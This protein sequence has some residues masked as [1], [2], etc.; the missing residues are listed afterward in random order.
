VVTLVQGK[1]IATTQGIAAL[2]AAPWMRFV[3]TERRCKIAE[4]YRPANPCP[5]HVDHIRS[6]K[7]LSLCRPGRSCPRARRFRCSYPQ[8]PDSNYCLEVLLLCT[9]CYKTFVAS[10]W[11]RT[12]DLLK[13][14]SC[15][16]VS[17]GW[18]EITGRKNEFGS[19]GVSASSMVQWDTSLTTCCTLCVSDAYQMFANIEDALQLLDCQQCHT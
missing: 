3:L 15:L 4:I 1:E 11:I 13:H 6:R 7:R 16:C 17:R 19:F 14:L 5:G 8:A 10:R 18:K 12:R 2:E 9:A